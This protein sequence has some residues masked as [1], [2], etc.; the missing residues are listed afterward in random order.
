MATLPDFRINWRHLL[1]HA[2]EGNVLNGQE[3]GNEPYETTRMSL[4]AIPSK[5]RDFV[6]V[7]DG[8]TELTFDCSRSRRRFWEDDESNRRISEM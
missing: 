4:L 3:R 1:L 5:S 7:F 6:G 2:I 8:F